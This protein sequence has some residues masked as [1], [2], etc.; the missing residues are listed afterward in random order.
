MH[1]NKEPDFCLLL[2]C[3]FFDLGGLGSE[4]LVVCLLLLD[5]FLQLCLSLSE[6]QPGR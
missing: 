2:R 4:K 3:D 6:A 5:V 1:Y